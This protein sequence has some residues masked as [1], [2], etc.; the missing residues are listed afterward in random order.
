MGSSFFPSHKILTARSSFDR[1]QKQLLESLQNDSDFG[2]KFTITWQGPLLSQHHHL[3]PTNACGWTRAAKRL[4]QKS[5]AALRPG[6]HSARLAASRRI[7]FQNNQVLMH[8]SHHKGVSSS[9][10]ILNQMLPCL[11]WPLSTRLFRAIY[12][13]S[14]PIFLRCFSIAH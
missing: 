6:K 13:M 1:S 3:N 8:L 2:L 11:N 14:R 5:R 12:L 9:I 10:A 4:F 7:L